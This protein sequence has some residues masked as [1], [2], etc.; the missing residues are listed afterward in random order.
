MLQIALPIFDDYELLDSGNFEKLERFGDHILARPEPQ[1]I[2]QKSLPESSWKQLAH[3]HF[4]RAQT[5]SN[6]EEAGQWTIKPDVAE[7][8]F[9][10]YQY[11]G[12]KLKFRLG[13]TSFK[14][15]GI[16]PEQANNWAFIYDTLNS[17]GQPDA[18]VLNLFAYTGGA[19]L[20]AK[21]AG[22]DVI[23]VDAVKQVISWSKQNMELSGLKDIRWVVEDA[24]KFVKKEVKRERL[25]EGIILDPPAYGRGPDG[26]KWVLEKNLDEMMAA[27]SLLLKPKGAFLILNLYSMGLSALVIETL[28]RKHFPDL[29]TYELGELAVQDKQGFK[30]PLGTYL[31]FQR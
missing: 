12:M 10:N 8:W 1:A 26:E 25:Y 14:H 7:Q 3:A 16:F 20:A 13:M 29:A 23:H 9:M 31:R 19:S 18:K 17:L 30:L 24:M 27:C 15:V 4:S 5:V 2:W 22:A 28:V 21:A 11:K 6:R